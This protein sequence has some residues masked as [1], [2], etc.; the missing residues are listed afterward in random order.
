MIDGP[1]DSLTPKIVYSVNGSMAALTLRI[2]RADNT[3][4]EDHLS[5]SI[6]DKKALATAVAAKL[7]E[8]AGQVPLNAAKQ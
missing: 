8:M 4:K 1:T 5:L 3:I 2:D 7:A 6:A